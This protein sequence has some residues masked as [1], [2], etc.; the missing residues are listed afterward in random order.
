[1]AR[2]SVYLVRHAFAAHADPDQWPDDSLRPVT[3]KGAERFRREARG[4]G[5]LVR[6]VDVV[7]SSRFA[8]AWQTAELL[9][10]AAGWPEPESCPELEAGRASAPAVEVLR[11]RPESTIALVGHEPHLSR[12]ASL[13][14]TGDEDR[15]DLR[16][17][18]GGVVLVSVDDAVEPG[19]ATF[20]WAAPP[21][22]LRALDGR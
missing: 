3:P 22:L 2:R 14:C 8:R 20:E 10:D 11:R 12:L 21:K 15:L 19:E 7:L 17:K 4:L 13:L 5:R 6:E 16:L 9:H 1:V 18:K